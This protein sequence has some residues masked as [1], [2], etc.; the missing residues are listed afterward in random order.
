[1]NRIAM[2][3]AD[4]RR[5]DLLRR[6]RPAPHGGSTAPPPVP[7]V[8]PAPGRAAA[9]SV[10]RA[11]SVWAGTASRSLMSPRRRALRGETRVPART[12]SMLDYRVPNLPAPLQ[13]PL[14]MSCWATVGTMMTSWRDQATHTL[15][16]FLTGLG[17]PWLTKF[18]Q[19]AG[20]FSAEMRTYLATM[21]M[22][23]EPAQVN[24]SAQGWEGLL[25]QFGPLWV[26]ADNNAAHAIQGVH[27]HML[28]GIH[29]PADGDPD[30]DVIDPGSGRLESMPLS[31]F[32]SRYEQLAG[33]DWAGLQ[34]RHWPPG[35]SRAAQQSLAWARQ[36]SARLAQEG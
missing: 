16:G 25:R 10:E 9:S 23:N 7:P 22:Q 31:R 12:L 19:N 11:M 8:G 33:T 29:G 17:G 32:V 2:L 15:S 20:L 1:M 21:G 4:L 30:A 28:V 34:V 14:S 18:E 35:A 3:E 13:Q 24:Y 26:T 36:A 27:E 6:R 5:G